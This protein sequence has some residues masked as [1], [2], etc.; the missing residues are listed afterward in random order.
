MLKSSGVL[1]II[2]GSEGD[3]RKGKEGK[4]SGGLARL[5]R[6]VALRCGRSSPVSQGF[7]LHICPAIDPT[8]AWTTVSFPKSIDTRLLIWLGGPGDGCRQ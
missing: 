5:A 7:S 8:I 6:L 4:E 3:A 2:S 1:T